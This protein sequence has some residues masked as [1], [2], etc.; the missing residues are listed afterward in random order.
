[1][2]GLLDLDRQLDLF[3]P[4]SLAITRSCNTV[5]LGWCSFWGAGVGV[6]E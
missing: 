2:N 4:F 5:K 3:G 1:M 6:R